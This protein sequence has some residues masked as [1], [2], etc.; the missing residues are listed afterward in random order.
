[1][2]LRQLEAFIQVVNHSSFSKAAEAVYLSQP[3]ISAYINSLEKELG[4][5]LIYRSTKEVFPTAAG[6]I[7]YEHAQNIVKL[8]ENS[9]FEIK[10]LSENPGGEINIAASSVPSQHVLPEIMAAFKRKFPGV[11]YRIT[12]SDSND[13][14]KSIK[15]YQCD[16]GVVGALIDEPRCVFDFFASDKLIMITPYEKRFIGITSFDPDFLRRQE[17]I[18]REQ[19]SGTRQ[20]FTRFISDLGIKIEELNIV[21]Q[22][23]N[24][25]G[26]IQAVSSGL[27]IS[28]VSSFA[29]DLYIREK[30]V[31]PIEPN[32]M[33]LN[34]A[35]Y[36]THKKDVLLS[37]I[38]E[39]FI[40][41]AK[42]YMRDKKVVC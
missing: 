31:H 19:G 22:M 8:L 35:F 38:A 11:T 27:G 4:T 15:A 2:D 42:E 16:F 32:N 41:F 36:F 13:V 12:Q 30:L 24:T 6:K 40:S 29:A 14:I 7:L 20:T 23:N 3:S 21:A 37:P 10:N 17:F 18:M 39:I 1:M 33:N 28:V 5:Q 25:Q 26:V 34:R 9:V